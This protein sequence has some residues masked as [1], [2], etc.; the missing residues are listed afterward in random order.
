M[1]AEVARRHFNV[2][3]YYRMAQAGIFS[4]DDRV[5]LI[6]GEIIEISPIGIGHA[7][8]V[9]RL[10]TLLAEQV[11]RRAIVRVQNPVRLDEF[12]EPQPD[13]ALLKWRDDFYSARHPLPPDVWL[14][15]EVAETSAAYDRKVKVPLYARAGIP[16]VW[17]IDLAQDVI[18]V[19]NQPVNG[20]YQMLAKMRR[21]DALVSGLPAL[22][23]SAADI[24]G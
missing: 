12:S 7:S 9:D 24:L 19:Y 20:V 2:A 5:E 14:I 21:G 16:E 8:C 6:E 23:L 15:A 18:E 13:I 4:E 22:T 17:L 10:V 1:S 11:G 3:E